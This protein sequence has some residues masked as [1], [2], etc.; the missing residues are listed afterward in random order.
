MARDEAIHGLQRCA[1]GL[2][3]RFAP[4]ND[5]KTVIA[6]YEAIRTSGGG[7]HVLVNEQLRIAVVVYV[8]GLAC[9]NESA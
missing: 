5:K 4:R 2:K 7:H 8:V 3:R 9:M 6:R 1:H